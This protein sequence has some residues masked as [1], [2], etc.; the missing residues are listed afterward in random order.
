MKNNVIR[1][2]KETSNGVALTKGETIRYLTVPGVVPG[3][4]MLVGSLLTTGILIRR[5]CSFVHS[6]TCGL[7]LLAEGARNNREKEAERESDIVIPLYLGTP[8]RNE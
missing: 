7:K 8:H 3:T 5:A 6:S 1:R 4:I 2:I